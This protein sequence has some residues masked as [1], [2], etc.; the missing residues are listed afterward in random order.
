[1]LWLYLL[2]P[3]TEQDS[4]WRRRG[5]RGWKYKVLLVVAV[6]K[7]KCRSFGNHRDRNHRLRIWQCLF[8]NWDGV[9]F[10]SFISPCSHHTRV[11]HPRG[12]STV[13]LIFQ[14]KLLNGSPHL[15]KHGQGVWW[16]RRWIEGSACRICLSHRTDI[17]RHDLSRVQRKGGFSE[18]VSRNA[19][20]LTIS[21]WCPNHPCQ[22]RFR[23]CGT[24][25]L[26]LTFEKRSS[27][28]ILCTRRFL[29]LRRSTPQSDLWDEHQGTYF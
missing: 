15:W 5:R 13:L 16:M 12:I 23:R 8:R 1:M 3:N 10:W 24:F 22:H 26:P 21:I 9:E 6:E 27:T 19:V 20:V 28:I 4:C 11:H 25:D 17:P 18:L 2:V 29:I 7:M 14:V